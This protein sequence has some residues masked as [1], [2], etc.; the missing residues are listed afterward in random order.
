MLKDILPRIHAR[1]A[2]T[3]RDQRRRDERHRHV[4]AESQEKCT[5]TLATPL[6]PQ[7]CAK[8]RLFLDKQVRQV[9]PGGPRRQVGRLIAQN[10]K[11]TRERSIRDMPRLD[12]GPNVCWRAPSLD[13]DCTEAEPLTQILPL[14]CYLYEGG[15]NQSDHTQ[16]T[17]SEMRTNGQLQTAPCAMPNHT[18]TTDTVGS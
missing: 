16:A 13:H 7:S 10:Q 6:S 11:V 1:R 15:C 8:A 17:R 14:M 4:R 9:I 5:Q 18:N 3:R 12:L 2:E